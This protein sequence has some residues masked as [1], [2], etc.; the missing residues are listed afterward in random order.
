VGSPPLSCFVAG[1]QAAFSK[2]MGSVT[3]ARTAQIIFMKCRVLGR[4]QALAGALAISVF[5]AGC[6][7]TSPG[8]PSAS[9]PPSAISVSVTPSVGTA[10]LGTTLTF[11]SQVINS[12][13]QAVVWNVNGAAGGSAQVGTITPQGIYTAPGDLPYAASVQVSATSVADPT[14]SAAANITITSDISI[15]LTPASSQVELGA[16]QAFHGAISSSGHP[17]PTIRWSVSGAACPSGCGNIDNSGNYTAPQI[18]PGTANVTITATSVADAS[19]QSSSSLAITSNFTL[20]LSAPA[21][22][23]AGTMTALVATMTPVTGSNPSTHLTWSLSGPGCTGSLCGTLSVITTQSA[24]GSV[25]AG[26]ANYTAPATPPQPDSILIAVTPQADPSKKAQAAIAIQGGASLLLSP[27]V[28]T[29]AANHRLTFTATES[30]VTGDSLKWSVNGI[31]GGSAVYGQVCVVGSKPCQSVSSSAASQVDYV[32]PGTIPTP[33]PVSVSVSSTSNPALAATAQ[34]TIINH[35]L[36]TVQPSSVTLAP[37]AVQG[38]TA[39]VL[40]TENQNVTWE[41]AGNGCQA[42]GSCGLITA[43]GAYT[44]PA[45]AP[46]PNAIQIVASSQDDP[47]QSSSSSV[48]VSTGASILTL[49]PASVYAGGADGFTLSVG[50]TGFSATN[51]GPGSTLIIG[52]T[53]RVTSCEAANSCSAPVTSADVAQVGSVTVQIQSL[54]LTRSNAV[55]LVVVAPNS[56]GDLIA[57]TSSRPSATGKDITVVD[58]TTTGIDSSSADFDLQVAALGTYV[59]A[60]GTC[61]LGGNPVLLVR[62][63]SGTSAADICLFSEAGL[64]TSMTYTVSG[65]GDVA[66]I[67]KL[68]AGLGII[69]LTLQIPFT[70]EAG[71][72]TLFIQNANLD[73][74]AAS[75]VLQIQ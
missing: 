18:L 65:P 43:E 32:A 69:H 36:V 6:A 54:D 47:T 15:S 50:G 17:D 3:S 21:I 39:T 53:A 56:S 35:V 9:A 62:P 75:G 73:E 34:I 59:T 26:T 23:N 25:V 57:L 68:P 24:G 64:D 72:R 31:P 42:T 11:S 70:A 20:T 16:V 37:L 63:G 66:V 30:G 10:L 28:A 22:V 4:G 29:L 52:G 12:S 67:A 1:P 41:I 7:G 45:A 46:T 19:R 74:T 55:A 8:M 49:H 27:G 33:N 58:P 48:V 40:G 5:L 14:K 2:S 71:A 51:P 61:N 38:F 44:A 13:N 60:T